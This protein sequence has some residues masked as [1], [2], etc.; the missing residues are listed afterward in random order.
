MAIKL[1]LCIPTYNFSAFIGETLESIICQATDE[2]EIVIIDGASVD[3]TAEVVERYQR[4]FPRIRFFQRNKNIGVDRDLAKSVE[5]A[6]GD[7][8]WFMSSDDKLKPGAIKRVLDEI[9][10]GHDI[11]IC[12]RIECDFY[13]RPLKK[14]LWLIS[15]IADKV[16]NFSKKDELIDY[17]EK[18]RSLGALFSYCSSIVFKRRKWNQVGCP[19]LFM[20]T[21]Y[22]HVYRLFSFA[23]IGC[24]TKYIKEMLV[25]CRGDN[26]SFLAKGLL[27]RFMLDI[28]G[29]TLLADNLFKNDLE[30][31]K[32]FF[33]V[34]R[35]E[36][37]LHYLIKVRS[38]VED[39]KLWDTVEKKLFYCG[40]SPLVVYA[41]RKL[42]ALKFFVSLAFYIKHK[43]ENKVVSFTKWERKCI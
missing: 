7:Y 32:L 17:L 38:S 21:G 27:K 5:L 25:L 41:A 16:F 36:I 22:A 29:Y 6:S 26:D 35:R 2:V 43:I 8:C 14:R 37:G 23:G 15:G 9:R 31:K 12:N 40:Y 13:L 28:D 39:M 4:E 3:D 30:L 24:K 1:S 34:L 42:G 18:S 10:E 33:A 20:G 19:E 11:Y